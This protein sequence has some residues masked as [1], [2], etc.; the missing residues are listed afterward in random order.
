LTRILWNNDNLPEKRTSA[1]H[2]HIWLPVFLAWSVQIAVTTRR[3]P[4][5][6]PMTESS[7]SMRTASNQPRSRKNFC[8]FFM[9]RNL[10]RGQN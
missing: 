10:F 9:I 1:P 4:N 7:I 6:E 8:L 2:T 3:R 5:P